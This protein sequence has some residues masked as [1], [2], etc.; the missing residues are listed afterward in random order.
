MKKILSVLLILTV[1]LS[2]TA[3]GSKEEVQINDSAIKNIQTEELEIA[4]NTDLKTTDIKESEVV[5]EESDS[6]IVV[7]TNI[8]TNET[9]VAVE[10]PIEPVIGDVKD[11]PRNDIGA[12][13]KKTVYD[14]NGI[15]ISTFGVSNK[16][17]KS[18]QLDLEVE[19][20]YSQP[21]IIQV[22]KAFIDDI[23][24]STSY[25][26]KVEKDTNV[27]DGV[28]FYS[29]LAKSKGIDIDNIGKISLDLYIADAST[30]VGIDEPI[31]VD[32][33]F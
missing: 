4:G 13:E 9:E 14:V 10:N 26:L 16:D 25:T 28:P 30:Y 23:E 12:L 33:E 1:V 11:E 8:L 24:I 20:N 27:N 17:D 32:F 21:I 2:L 22:K 7:D 18:F 15:K 6:P 19:N 31:G 5:K 3:C 29:D